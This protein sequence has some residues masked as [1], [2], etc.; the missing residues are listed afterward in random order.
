MASVNYTYVYF[1]ANDFTGRAVLSAFTL[2][3]TSLTFVPDFLTSPVLSSDDSISNKLLRW[4]FGDGTFSSLLTA[5]HYYKWP[6]DYKVRLTVYDKFGNAYDSSYQPTIK[7][8][9]FIRDQLVFKDFRRFIYD[10]PA[11]KIIEPIELLRQTSWQSYNALSSTGYTVHLY[12]SGALGQFQ[13]IDNFYDDKWS[14]LRALSRFYIKTPV[15]DSFE[16]QSVDRI[17]KAGEPIFAKIDNKSFR[18]C[19]KND[20]GSFFVGTTASYEF[21]YVDDVTKNYTSREPPIFIFATLD[22]SKFPDRYTINSDSYRDISY[23]PYGYN[24]IKPAVLPIIKV[25]HNPAEKLN[26]TTTGIDGE[27]VLSTTKFYFPE[28]SWQNTEIP[29]L[30]KMKDAD[31]FTT[32]TYPPIYSSVTDSSLSGLT[33]FNVNFGLQRKEGSNFYPVTGV[34]FFDDFNDEIPRS[35]GAF[36]KGYFIVNEPTYNLQLTARMTVK[37]PINY[38]KDTFIGW[39]AV[40]Q[41]DVLVRLFREQIYGSCLGGVT[42]SISAAKNFVYNYNNRNVYAI[43]VAPSGAGIGE[44]YQAWFADGSRD[45][46]IKFT[47][48]GVLL[49]SFTLSAYPYINP[50]TGIKEYVNLLNPIL[51]SAAPASITL[52][53]ENNLWFCLAD[54]VSSI[55]IDGKSGYM[56]SNAYP[57][58][59]NIC[60]FLSGD[61]HLPF[62][63]GFAG[64]NL[65][66]PVSIDSDFNNDIWVSYTHPVCGFIAK[67]STYGSLLCVVPFIPLHSPA[68]I[69][70]DRNKNVW[71]TAY[72]LA[73]SGYTLSGRNDYVY[74]F[75]T[76]GDLS[77]GYPISGFKFIHNATTDMFQNLWVAQDRD[78]ITRIDGVNGSTSNYIAGS[79]NS[80]SYIGSIG[81]LAS[82]T[83]DFLWILNNFDQKLYFIDTLAPKVS[84]VNYLNSVDLILP[85]ESPT[86]ILSTFAERSFQAYGDWLGTRWINKRMIPTTLVRTITGESNFFNIL[87]LSGQYSIS[88]VNENFDAAGFYKSLIFSEVLED[89]FNLFNSFIGTIVGGITAQPYELGKTVYEKIAN[90]VSNKSDIDKCNLDALISFCKELS[91]QFEQYNYPFPPQLTRLV[92]ILSIK[93]SNLWGNRNRF[94]LDFSKKGTQFNDNYAKNRGSELSTKT[95][96]ITAGY[97]VVAY[98]TFSGLYSLVN[99]IT[100]QGYSYGDVIPLSSFNSSWGWSLVIPGKLSGS[101]I[102]DF[103]KFYE[104]VDVYNDNYFNN[105]IDW[106]SPFTTINFTNSSFKEWT[107]TNGIM[108]SLINYELTKGLRLILSASDIVYNN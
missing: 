58:V 102:S 75:N 59:T 27:G 46:L 68:E 51:S 97:P 33:S 20:I 26:I 95:S 77:S 72:N 7:V 52:D 16:Y 34:Q 83:N 36:F 44:D 11:S 19:N 53:G 85:G 40:P 92:N 101:R 23:P 15:G 94:N 42:L 56:L 62:L 86:N 35:I 69:I 70:I 108:D 25:R 49:S 22:N 45:S 17:T 43:Q 37:D 65:V 81:G 30:I 88:K 96:Y 71:V 41:Y 21:F 105:I 73:A 54:A 4:D 47:A 50:N 24:N 29:F 6:G 14:H 107:K 8:Y 61:Y 79:A 99:S 66:Y 78:T 60:Y 2:P 89:K 74:K 64:E 38:P 57:D 12:A 80:T 55:K 100:I 5:T 3:Q 1:R 63:S 13:N 93:H 9:D 31:N 32:K 76:R 98:E 90:F 104:F 103:Y 28:L 48:E 39:A 10:V 18:I 87:P 82:D 67:Y 91:I 84:S 106:E